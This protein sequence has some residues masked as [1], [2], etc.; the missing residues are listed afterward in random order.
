MLLLYQY[1]FEFIYEDIKL[2]I[3]MKPLGYV[4]MLNNRQASYNN[5]STQQYIYNNTLIH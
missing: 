4:M 2:Q 1:I 3:Q 5:K